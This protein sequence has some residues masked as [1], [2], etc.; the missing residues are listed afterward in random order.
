MRSTHLSVLVAALSVAVLSFARGEEAVPSPPT[1]REAVECLLERLLTAGREVDSRLLRE[2]KRRAAIAGPLLREL[3]EW[4]ADADPDGL[5]ARLLELADSPK[6]HLRC[7][8]LYG[9]RNHLAYDG[10]YDPFEAGP[11]LAKM[12]AEL[13]ANMAQQ[14]Q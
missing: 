8:A 7:V 3:F 11:A 9:L 13:R 2:L 5:R 1:E 10:P 6:S 12:A 14:P 4:V